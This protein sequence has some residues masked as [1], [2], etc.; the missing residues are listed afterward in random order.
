MTLAMEETNLIGDTN[1]SPIGE[2]PRLGW[3][4]SLLNAEEGHRLISAF[5]NIRQAA[6]RE[7]VIHLVSEVSKLH[8]DKQ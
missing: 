1:A 2:R 3:K 8:D 4:P 6:L 5:L 7:A